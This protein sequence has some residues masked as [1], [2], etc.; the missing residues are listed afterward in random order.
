MYNSETKLRSLE[1]CLRG[2]KIFHRTFNVIQNISLN[3]ICVARLLGMVFLTLYFPEG[4]SWGIQAGISTMG[5][6]DNTTTA[7]KSADV[8]P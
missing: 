4:D 6:E 2:Q 1:L 7:L 5:Y 8:V 3:S